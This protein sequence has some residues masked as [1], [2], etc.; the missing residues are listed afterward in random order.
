MRT[1]ELS[2]SWVLSLANW[3][4]VQG[5]EQSCWPRGLVV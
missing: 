1:P 2:K 5:Q 4:C 3:L